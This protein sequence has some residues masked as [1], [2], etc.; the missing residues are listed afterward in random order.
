MREKH[1]HTFSETGM[2]LLLI[3]T[4]G[5]ITG[6]LFLILRLIGR[7]HIVGLHWLR[8]NQKK[9]LILTANHPSYLEPFLL[10]LLFFPHFLI[11]P[12]RY[13]PW[14]TPDKKNFHEQWYFAWM[15]SL[16][17]IAIDRSAY[18]QKN[19]GALR[20][21]M[22]ALRNGENLIIFPEGGRT[23]KRKEIAFSNN[24]KSLGKLQ[25]GV[26]RIQSLAECPI[27]PVWIENTDIV[28]PDKKWI[29][30]F[31]RAKIIIRIG[32]PVEKYI[33]IQELEHMLRELSL[34]N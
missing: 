28:L 25:E 31:W 19:I 30:R 26:E 12:F 27:V 20:T 1:T 11:H 5:L 29:P 18:L 14:N 22:T 33:T 17:W 4:V 34:Q 2:F 8:K 16:R 23:F 6:T 7:I 15:R 21:M 9:G 3:Y 32:A 13:F 24:G 10:P